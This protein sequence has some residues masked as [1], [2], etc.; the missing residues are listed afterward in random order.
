MTTIRSCSGSRFL[1]SPGGIEQQSPEERTAAKKIDPCFDDLFFESFGHGDGGR[2][3]QEVDGLREE[4]NA[5]S[6]SRLNPESWT[7]TS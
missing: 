1:E 3:G 5:S 2:G 7:G 4:N 6:L